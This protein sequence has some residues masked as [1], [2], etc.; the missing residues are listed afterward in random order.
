MKALSV[1]QPWAWCIAE[2][3]KDVEN[4]TWRTRHRG[5]LLIHASKTFDHEGYL[6]IR[7]Q[8]GIALPTPS[9]FYRGC[10]IATVCIADCV[11]ESDSPWFSG[12]YGFVLRNPCRFNAV[13][14]R[15]MPGLFD[16]PEAELEIPEWFVG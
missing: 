14:Y 2:G 7:S 8:M 12:P 5:G 11:T 10:L 3:L 1:R 4:R 6:W 9:A 15:G 16:V 13:E